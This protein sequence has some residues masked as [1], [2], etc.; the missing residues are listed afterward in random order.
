MKNTKSEDL[1]ASAVSLAIKLYAW[2]I[3]S[4]GSGL[5]EDEKTL[6]GIDSSE[7]TNTEILAKKELEKPTTKK[8]ICAALTI[9]G[10]DLSEVTKVVS[11]AL[12]PLS[13]SGVIAIPLTP[14]ALAVSGLIV[15]KSGVAAYCSF[16]GKI[17]KE[18]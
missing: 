2:E 11:S 10:N 13:L 6:N 8:R 1:V 16:E 14:L 5:T 12:I 9:V 15:F 18:K 3:N 17:E 7:I 4:G